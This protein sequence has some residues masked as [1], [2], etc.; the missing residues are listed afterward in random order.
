M[1]TIKVTRKRRTDAD[2]LQDAR[3]R[4]TRCEAA[5]EKAQGDEAAVRARIA[6]KIAALQAL[7]EG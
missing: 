6:D 3:E 4:V 1:T 5:L 7:A 2:D